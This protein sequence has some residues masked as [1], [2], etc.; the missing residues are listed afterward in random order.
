MNIFSE[1]ICF[2]YLFVLI[3]L[4][5]SISFGNALVGKGG[6]GIAASELVANP[7]MSNSGF[8]PNISSSVF[9]L[10]L[11]VGFQNIKP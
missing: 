9:S 2:P 4:P 11:P 10:G 6:L 8:V 1:I 3:R 5:V 7:F